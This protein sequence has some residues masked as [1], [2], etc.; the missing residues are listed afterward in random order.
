MAGVTLKNIYKIYPN[1]GHE[2]RAVS[3]FSLEI[4]DREVVV[5][6]GPSGCGKTSTLRMIAGLEAIDKGELYIGGRLVNDVEPKDRDIAMLFQSFALFPH[7]TVFENIAFGLEPNEM[8]ESEI[9]EKVVETAGILGISHILDRKPDKLSGGQKQRTALARAMIR[10]SKV[11]LLDE[12]LS[13]LDQ[14]LRAIM[15]TELLRLHKKFETTF[16]YVTHDQIEAMTI[17]DRIV[18]M[19]D[20]FIQQV[21]TPEELYAHPDNLFVAGFLGRPQ[22]DFFDAKVIEKGGDIFIEFGENKIKL[23]EHKADKAGAYASKEVIAGIRPGDFHVCEAGGIDA[24]VEIREF[25]GDVIYLHCT[26]GDLRFTVRVPPD[27]AVKTGDK[28]NIAANP[29]RIYLFDKDTEA[30]I[31]N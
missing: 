19:K 24:A 7:M 9:K 5:L 26:N 6:L 17:A 27:C 31:A 1:N 4:K 29:D 8:P 13:N 23:P 14:W 22:M 12:P 21:G 30:A 15:R 18:I 2:V 3:D 10:K 20:G 25:M 16:I 11:V 28:I